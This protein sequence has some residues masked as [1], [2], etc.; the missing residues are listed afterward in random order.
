[1]T[2]TL[3]VVWAT[4]FQRHGLNKLWY[5]RLRYAYRAPSLFLEG[6][7]ASGAEV[8]LVTFDENLDDADLEPG[9]AAQQVDI[10]YVATHGLRGSSGF[11][12]ALHAGDW[13]LLGGGFGDH[14]PSIVI[15]DCCDLVD[16]GGTDWDEQW[17][18]DKLG[19][20]LRLVLGFASPASVSLQ[21]SIRGTAFARELTTKPVTDAWFVS[22]Q[23]GSY[24][25]TDKPVAIAFGD[26]DQDARNVLDQLCI[27]ALPGPR[28]S[29]VPG[30]A[31]RS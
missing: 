14:G 13:P 30:V 7:L 12:L 6:M 22:I 26:D 19:P 15:F 5:R 4:H 24:V 28:T 9:G 11:E 27:G 25:G 18:T 29:S 17:R 21:A 20:E 1:M 2:I 3:G 31:W 16:L 8:Q 23:A 10:L